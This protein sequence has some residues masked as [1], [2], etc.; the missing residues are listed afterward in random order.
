MAD[1][2]L[3]AVRA[4]RSTPTGCLGKDTEVLLPRGDTKRIQEIEAGE[5]VV[6]LDGKPYKVEGL[7]YRNSL[8]YNIQQ[9]IGIDQYIDGWTVSDSYR[10]PLIHIG[11][12]EIKQVGIKT[13]LNMERSKQAG[14]RLFKATINQFARTEA[15]IKNISNGQTPAYVFGKSLAEHSSHI[16]S[17]WRTP[18]IFP[19]IN[20]EPSNRLE[21]LAGFFDAVGTKTGAGYTAHVWSDYVAESILRTCWSTGIHAYSYTP[22]MGGQYIRVF[23]DSG[24]MIPSHKYQTESNINKIKSNLVLPAYHNFMSFKITEDKSREAYGLALSDTKYYLLADY[25][26]ASRCEILN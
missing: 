25:T 18:L 9:E 4:L 11:T 2:V 19:Y 10:L 16:L 15:D 1:V 13:W 12:K 6:G 14:H 26:V 8:C 23:E 17:G 22:V 24:V 5:F 21:F 7:H 3:D 20:D